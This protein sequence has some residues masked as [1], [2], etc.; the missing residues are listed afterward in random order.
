M[1]V[2]IQS[3]VS[4]KNKKLYKF[5]CTVFATNLFLKLQIL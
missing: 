4:D 5:Y 1:A 2:F 3:G